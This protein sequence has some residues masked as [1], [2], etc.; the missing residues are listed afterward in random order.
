MRRYT[1]VLIP[2][3]DGSAYHVTVPSLP[4][5]V[6]FGTTVE[7]AL[8]M[9]RDV[10]ALYV[11]TLA[12]QGEQIPEEVGAPLVAAVDVPDPLPVGR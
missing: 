5:C 9:A 3:P 8:E 10:I 6:T 11:A 12:D 1:V 2:E 7:E 4:G